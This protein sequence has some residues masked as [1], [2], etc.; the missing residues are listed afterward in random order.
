VLQAIEQVPA[1]QVVLPLGSVG[2]TVQVAPH[3]E[4]L[5]SRAQELPQAW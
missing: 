1:K 3:A 5:S 4:A 2:H